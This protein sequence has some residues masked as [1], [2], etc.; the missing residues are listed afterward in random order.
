M[1]RKANPTLIGGF[2]LGAIVLALGAA[3][4]LG[5]GKFLTNRPRAVVFFP[6]NIQGLAIGAPVTLR[7]VQV[8]SVAD[9]R[10]VLN[11][12]KM[13]PTIPVYL[14]FDP[15]RLTTNKAELAP[16]PEQ[17]HLR[18]AIANGLH[19][20]L[21]TQSFVTG[22]LLVELDLDPNEPRTLVGAD[23]STI[24]IPTSPSD[25]EKLRSAL[26]QIPVDR[27][28]DE[29]LRLLNHVDGLVT[30]PDLTKLLQ[31]LSVLA[32]NMNSL[33][34]GARGDL[35]PLT[36]DLRETIRSVHNTMTTSQETLAEMRKALATADQLMAT[37]LRTTVKT[38]TA[39][40]E[41]AQQ[42]AIEAQSVVSE[43]SAQR[44][45]IDQT[46][47]NLTAATRSLRLLADELQRRP[48]AVITGK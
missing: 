11:V 2:V 13:Q 41:A 45:D 24:E 30:S 38:A 26:A 5:A 16:T 17:Q 18:T 35:P 12:D 22:Q 10:I 19:A 4:A 29:T 37:D 43:N 15:S 42:V 3:I 40:L 46:L 39:A 7:G 25:I 33:I 34:E 47:R 31:S 32:S 6:G 48:N 44:D 36:S 23:P 28:A 1:S 27:I 21:A 9:I 20:R 8:G 14:E